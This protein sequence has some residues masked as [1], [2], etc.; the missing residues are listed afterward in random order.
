MEFQTLPSS[1]SCSF[2]FTKIRA[3]SYSNFMQ[4][5]EICFFSTAALSRGTQF[6]EHRMTEHQAFVI[7]H[8]GSLAQ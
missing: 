5:R 2:P 6:D 7:P 8:L 3:R 4:I 1:L